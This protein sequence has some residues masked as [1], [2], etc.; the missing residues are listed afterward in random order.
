LNGIQDFFNRKGAISER[1]MKKKAFYVLQQFY[2]HKEEEFDVKD[3]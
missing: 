2:R 1:G 3:H